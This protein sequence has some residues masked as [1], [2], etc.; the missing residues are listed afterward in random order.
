MTMQSGAR[1]EDSAFRVSEVTVRQIMHTKAELHWKQT[2]EYDIDNRRYL[3]F[4]EQT[5]D[6]KEWGGSEHI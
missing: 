2:M 4:M 3:K 1:K 5:L 6:I